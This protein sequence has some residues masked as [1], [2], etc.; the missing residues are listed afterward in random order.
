[1]DNYFTSTIISKYDVGQL[2][3]FLTSHTC[4][5]QYIATFMCN[6][7]WMATHDTIRDLDHMQ[8]SHSVARR[9]HDKTVNYWVL[10]I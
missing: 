8:K 5:V 3:K 1:M 6:Y 10:L 2:N 4:T 9:L 7:I